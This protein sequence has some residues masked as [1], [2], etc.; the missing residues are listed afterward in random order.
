MILTL[1]LPPTC[2]QPNRQRGHWAK[3]RKAIADCRAIAK[4]LSREA[5]GRKGEWRRPE[6]RPT[7]YFATRR[8]RDDDNLVGWL[9]SYRDGIADGLGVNDRDMFTQRPVQAVD[10]DNPRVEIEIVEAG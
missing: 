2:L 7:F 3:R 6:L 1:P 4:L 8:H 10:R 5:D 9:K